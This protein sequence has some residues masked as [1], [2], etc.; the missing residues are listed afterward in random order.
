[1][2]PINDPTPKLLKMVATG[3]VA[4]TDL[5]KGLKGANDDETTNKLLHMQAT[6]GE[7]VVALAAACF[8][9]HGWVPDPRPD[10]IQELI[11]TAKADQALQRETQQQIPESSLD[12]ALSVAMQVCVGCLDGAKLVR[13]DDP[14]DDKGVRVWKDIRH[15]V[16]KERMEQAAARCAGDALHT[17]GV[18]IGPLDK[19]ERHHQEPHFGGI[20]EAD[21]D[22]YFAEYFKRYP[23]K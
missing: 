13:K 16:R 20:S 9:K 6:V 17:A 23:R 11:T 1:M 2:T 8:Q 4:A 22:K 5:P 15:D 19:K 14:Y 10:H 7:R 18:A 3:I 21:Q 12:E